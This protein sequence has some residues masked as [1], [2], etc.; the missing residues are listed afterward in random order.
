MGTRAAEFGVPNAK[1]RELTFAAAAAPCAQGT[2]AG[3][4]AGG[5]LCGGGEE[6]KGTAGAQV[7]EG[8]GG[9]RQEKS[10]GMRRRREGG[11]GEA[12]GGGADGQEKSEGRRR[13]G[14]GG[15]GEPGGGGADAGRGRRVRARG[16]REGIREALQVDE[17]EVGCE[18]GSEE[19]GEK[20]GARTRKRAGGGGSVAT[21]GGGGGRLTARGGGGK[22][23]EEF[24]Y[25]HTFSKGDVGKVVEIE[26]VD[27]GM[28][29]VY[30]CVYVCVC[31]YVCVYIHYP[32]FPASSH[33]PSFLFFPP[34]LKEHRK[35]ARALE[36]ERWGRGGE[37][38]GKHACKTRTHT[39]TH[40]RTYAHIRTRARAHTHTHTHTHTHGH[41][42]AAV[43]ASQT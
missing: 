25:S 36:R 11:A 32:S 16:E 19:R 28:V 38:G 1:S 29:P 39:R 20:A 41:A 31:M 37:I 43:E 33:P 3:G 4:R 14:E 9:N 6:R 17:L 12:G 18:E 5:N 23:T 30:V 34:S 13:R 10:E 8:V 26:C 2:L 15:G 35:C 40:T 24:D 22:A 42:G 27:D 7:L 21:G